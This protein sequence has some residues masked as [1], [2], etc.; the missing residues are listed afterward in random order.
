MKKVVAVIVAVVAVVVLSSG[1]VD[2]KDKQTVKGM[3]AVER[4]AKAK[5]YLFVFFYSDDS[6]QTASMRGIFNSAVSQLSKKAERVE[7]NI[8][9]PQE[10]A[11]VDKYGVRGAPMPLV[12]AIA[13]NGAVTGG[14]PAP[15]GE[16]QI[17]GAFATPCTQTAVKAIQENKLV[18]LCIQNRKTQMNAAAMK[19]VQD[20]KADPAYA[21]STEI[22]MLDPSDPA[23]ANLLVNLAISPST[24]QAMTVCLVPSGQAVAKLTGATTKEMI[25]S[26]L[27]GGGGGCAPGACGGATNCGPAAGGQTA[28]KSAGTKTAAKAGAT[29][30]GGK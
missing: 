12:L 19:G 20:F 10:A 26:S 13:P 18:L 7:V 9:D 22:V 28:T 24:D 6:E 15:F 1:F 21:A 5:K 4:A 29:K 23:E 16:E 3:A 27:K 2:A 25:A 17:L 30:P 11:I 14:F 8:T